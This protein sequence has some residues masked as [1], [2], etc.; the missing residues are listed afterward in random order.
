MLH[1][2]LQRGLR[3][4]AGATVYGC[5]WCDHRFVPP[6]EKGSFIDASRALQDHLS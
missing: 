1:L 6:Q 2:C 5:H 4:P 3:I